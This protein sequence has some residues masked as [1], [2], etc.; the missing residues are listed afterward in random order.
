MHIPPRTALQIKDVLVAGLMKENR[1]LS[2]IQ[3][4]GMP[5]RPGGLVIDQKEKVLSR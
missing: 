1:G 2:N 4:G 5:Y 3:V